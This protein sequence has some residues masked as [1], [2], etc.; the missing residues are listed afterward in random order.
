LGQLEG[1]SKVVDELGKPPETA[2]GIAARRL[3]ADTGITLAQATELVRFLGP[4]NWS[5]LLREARILKK[6]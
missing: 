2:S 4:Y 6:P 1:T 3:A 5:S